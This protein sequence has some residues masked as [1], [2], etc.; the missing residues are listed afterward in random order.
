MKGYESC[1]KPAPHPPEK[2]CM[3]WGME[4]FSTLM[5]ILFIMISLTFIIGLFVST[6]LNRSSRRNSLN[7]E[8]LI[9]EGNSLKIIHY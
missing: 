8:R 2:I 5:I 6:K 4:C 3:L 7:H 1:P 9:K